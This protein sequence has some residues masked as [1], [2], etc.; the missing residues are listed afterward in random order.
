MKW[1]PNHKIS[2][3]PFDFRKW[4]V[5]HHYKSWIH[6]KKVQMESIKVKT[7]KLFM[8]QCIRTIF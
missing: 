2:F 6:L 7:I 1:G 3:C 8:L 4:T 5:T